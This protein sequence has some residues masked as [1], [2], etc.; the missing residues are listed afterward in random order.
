MTEQQIITPQVS[1]QE[2]SL[3]YV[4][5]RLGYDCLISSTKSFVHHFNSLTD[6]EKTEFK[7]LATYVKQLEKC[8]QPKQ[9]KQTNRRKKTVE[10][11]LT[12][13]VVEETIKLVPVEEK[14]K[15]LT[16]PV[17]EKVIEPV[18]K[19]SKRTSKKVETKEESP[20]NIA[21]SEVVETKEVEVKVETKAVEV[22]EETKKP[23]TKKSTNT[24]TK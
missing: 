13:T 15:E 19:G 8:L 20:T 18:Q 11:S 7:S 6:E 21:I 10:V 2:R 5:T 12:S 16:L 1:K 9:I 24:K 14:V 4:S 22:K 17:E 3:N 23:A